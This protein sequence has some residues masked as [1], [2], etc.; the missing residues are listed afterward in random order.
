M[1]VPHGIASCAQVS[2]TWM[3]LL[4]ALFAAARSG[5][6]S[7]CKLHARKHKQFPKH[8]QHEAGPLQQQKQQPKIHTNKKWQKHTHTSSYMQTLSGLFATFAGAAKS[9]RSQQKLLIA[10]HNHHQQQETT[11]TT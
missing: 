5:R 3:R 8:D 4:F 6:R 7:V 2:S 10:H 9:G 1:C 11:A